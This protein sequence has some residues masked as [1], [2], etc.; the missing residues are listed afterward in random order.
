MAQAEKDALTG[1]DTTGHEWDGIKEL[2]TPLPRWW[3]WTFW[4]TIIWAVGYWVVY[5]AWPTLSNYTQGVW[6]YSSRAAHE[7][8]MQQLKQ[9]RA[10]WAT[11]FE[12]KPVSAI[13]EDQQLLNYAMAGGE[14]I[15]A[16][17]CA[18]CHGAG[19]QGQK[20]YPTL[21]DDVW[22]WGGAPEEIVTTIRYGV[23]SGHP[24]TRY[25][26]MPKFVTDG[27]LTNE[28]AEK[29]ADYVLSLSGQGAGNAEGQQIFE[30]QC[31]AC[32]G[33]GG[34]GQPMLGGP[35]LSDAIWL[36]EGG[37]DGVLAQIKNPKHGV[38]PA[39]TN[40]LSDVEIKQVATYV[41][42]LGGAK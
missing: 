40:R 1:T 3:V 12:E 6:D 36:Y 15:F 35:R 33:E 2:N 37:K 16:E 26:E 5:P 19:G 7:Q 29:V 32:H 18:P 34:V 22:I 30:E 27:I 4:V 24:D 41:Y 17:N 13:L 10:A 25:N 9:Q 8:D 28:Q 39:W 23:R 31:V 42:T 14:F 20:G 11:K 21:A 38:M